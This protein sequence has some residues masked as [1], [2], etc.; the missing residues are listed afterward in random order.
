MGCKIPYISCPYNR[1]GQQKAYGKPIPF[2][3][4]EEKA[5]LYPYRGK[6]IAFGGE[7]NSISPSGS[8]IVK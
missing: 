4:I 6:G 3:R 2:G 8:Y 1:K 5:V 7:L